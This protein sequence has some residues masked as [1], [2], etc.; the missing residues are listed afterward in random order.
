[1]EKRF[2]IVNND[3]EKYI[4]NTLAPLDDELRIIHENALKEGIPVVRLETLRVLETYLAIKKPDSILELGC[5]IGFT[6]IFFSRYLSEKGFIDTVEN[7]ISM[8]NRAK[9]NIKMKSL[10]KKIN[11]IYAEAMDY[12]INIDR[13]YDIIFI[14]AAKGQYEG[15][16][17]IC[18]RL[19]NDNGII[20]ADNV[21]YRGM[22]AKGDKIPHRQNTLVERLRGFLDR[23]TK[24]ERFSTSILSVGD[25]LSISVKK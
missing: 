11:I 25:G 23:I 10:D 18:S 24:D 1:M 2:S 17:D 8:V 13:K 7:D 12:L 4:V 19:V 20:I 9:Y 5:A 21:L 16:F 15:Y 14:D 3:V 6:S 22:V